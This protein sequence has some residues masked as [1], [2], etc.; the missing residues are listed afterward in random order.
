[1]K[2]A[3]AA[4]ATHAASRH[5]SRRLR[6]VC[7]KTSH[8]WL[9]A[10]SARDISL[11][12]R[13]INSSIASSARML[14]KPA[15]SV[16][17]CAIASAFEPASIIRS[18]RRRSASPSRRAVANSAARSPSA[19]EIRPARLL[20]RLQ[21]RTHELTFRRIDMHT[22][23]E[24]RPLDP[25]DLLRKTEVTTPYGRRSLG[26]RRPLRGAGSLRSTHGSHP[27]LP[28]A[29]ALS[30]ILSSLSLVKP[31]KPRGGHLPQQRLRHLLRPPF[32][33]P[34]LDRERRWLSRPAPP[35]PHT[36]PQTRASVSSLPT[37]TREAASASPHH[38]D[39]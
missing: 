27:L 39:P 22:P 14:A 38:R 5:A 19:A 17:W 3:K 37:C 34:G 13:A 12:I 2:I 29:R 4:A 23:V 33:H 10:R 25:R 26:A 28:V 36:L 15:L 6:S 7:F 1:M 35:C 16:A 30:G 18:I 8:F 11:A 32:P 20:N 31:G 24:R 21:K 9:S